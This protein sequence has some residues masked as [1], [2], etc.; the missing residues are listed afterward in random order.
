[1]VCQLSNVI[2]DLSFIFL[3]QIRPNEFESM[4]R[5]Y[6]TMPL[7]MKGLNIGSSTKTI[8]KKILDFNILDSMK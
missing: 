5:K 7:T 2:I 6:L 3:Y 8:Y 1:M 4:T